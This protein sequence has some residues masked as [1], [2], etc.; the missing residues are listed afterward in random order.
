MSDSCLCYNHAD[1]TK[2]TLRQ[3]QRKTKKQL[4]WHV[5]A[6]DRE[7][8]LRDKCVCGDFMTRVVFFKEM[9]EGNYFCSGPRER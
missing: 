1:R 9:H 8:R 4:S 7:V 5:L 3:G 6:F 2:P